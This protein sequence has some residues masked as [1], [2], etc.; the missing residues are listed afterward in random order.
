MEPTKGLNPDAEIVENAQG[1]K[2][3]E[4]SYR[5]DLVPA[6]ASF[7]VA[8]VFA[9]GAKRYEPWNWL[10]IPLADHLNS[11]LGHINAYMMGDDQDDHLEHAACRMMMALELHMLGEDA[12]QPQNEDDGEGDDDDKYD[13]LV[14]NDAQTLDEL[15]DRGRE[16]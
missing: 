1:G 3:S 14:E 2:Q 6:R 5:F 10:K 12:I 8:E 13:V 7:A 4:K 11:V 16:Q 15:T 9:Y